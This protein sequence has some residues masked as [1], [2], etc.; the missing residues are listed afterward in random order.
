MVIHMKKAKI[1]IVGLGHYIYFE[2]FQGLREELRQKSE[3]FKNYID[4][5]SC[6]LID[7]GYVDRVEDSFDAVR[8]LKKEDADLLF[9]ILLCITKS[10]FPAFCLT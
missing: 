6:D 8:K 7:L 2:Q 4:P 5:A 9:I 10:S 1:A 3:A